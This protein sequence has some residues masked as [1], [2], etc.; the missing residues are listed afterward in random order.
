V[1]E[2]VRTKAYSHIESIPVLEHL[3]W[4][5]HTSQLDL[6]SHHSTWKKKENE[7]ERKV[8]L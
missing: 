7:R 1:L 4:K 8:S 6:L 2:Q 3:V 5:D